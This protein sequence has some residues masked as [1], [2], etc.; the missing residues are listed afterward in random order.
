M[1]LFVLMLGF[2]QPSI[3]KPI[4]TT[5]VKTEQIPLPKSK[6]GFQRA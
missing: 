1:T 6:D 5:L 4:R 2:N 3:T